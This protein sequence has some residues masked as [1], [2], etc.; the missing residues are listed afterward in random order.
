VDV[1]VVVPNSL[2]K[3]DKEAV[4]T[5]TGKGVKVRDISSP[6]MH[7]K[8][9]VVDGKKAFVGSVNIS[10][11]SLDNNRELGILVSDQQ[12]I[13]TLEQTFAKD[14]VKAA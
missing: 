11:N 13:Q 5:L 3:D 7:A 10:K 9:I 4:K 14:W 8:I 2:D 12:V 6:Y 1:Q